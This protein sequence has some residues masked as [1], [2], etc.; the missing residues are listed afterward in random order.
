ML[1]FYRKERLLRVKSELTQLSSSSGRNG[2][3]SA[4]VK[5]IQFQKYG[6]PYIK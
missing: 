4:P 5:Q 3:K 2:K 1:G 6:L